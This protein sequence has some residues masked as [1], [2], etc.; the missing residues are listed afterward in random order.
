MPENDPRPVAVQS[1]ML[2]LRKNR[3]AIPTPLVGVVIREANGDASAV[4]RL[5]LE[6]VF[7]I[8]DQVDP[9][10]AAVAGV[11]RAWVQGAESIDAT[12][13]LE[14]AMKE[15]QNAVPVLTTT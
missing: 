8:A 14:R 4:N 1:T 15:L 3:V 5:S 7:E 11:L 6:E 12:E 13:Q 2:A 9:V 10:R